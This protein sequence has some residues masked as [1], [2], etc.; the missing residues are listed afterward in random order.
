[1]LT[2]IKEENAILVVV[3]VVYYAI[4]V[5]TIESWSK[6]KSINNRSDNNRDNFKY[7]N[8]NENNSNDDGDY[9]NEDS[10]IDCNKTMPT[11][12]T[13]EAEALLMLLVRG[14]LPRTRQPGFYSSAYM[15]Q[16]R[17]F[18]E[19]FSMIVTWGPAWRPVP[20]VQARSPKPWPPNSGN[21]A[22]S[23]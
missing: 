15:S 5:A 12:W 20:H 6:L 19:T 11:L 23:C 14:R 2:V 18:C 7:N 17:D 1:M 13:A 21:L 8:K 22:W 9:A 10:E 3:V 4:L 16:Y